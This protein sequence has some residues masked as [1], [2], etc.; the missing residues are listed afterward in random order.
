MKLVIGNKAY[1][2]WSLRPWIVMQAFGIAFDEKLVLLREKDTRDRILEHSPSGKV[3]ALIDDGTLVWDSL[4][5]IEYLADKYLQH[6]IWPKDQL[7]RAHARCASAEMHSGFQALRNACSMNVTRTFK[8]RDRG[9]AVAADVERI[10]A[11]WREA[12]STFGSG[13][14]FLYGDFSGAD[15][16]FAP[17]VSRFH[18]YAIEVDAVSRA[19]M[20]AIMA[21]PAYKSWVAAA[22]AEPWALDNGEADEIIVTDLR[23]GKHAT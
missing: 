14:T 7:A 22:M 4:A 15:G 11:L 20:T 17:V 9:P 8:A 10:T 2:S 16:M 6:G 1:S 21:H 18:A 3:P 13:G 23:A 12:R 5:I 19:Y